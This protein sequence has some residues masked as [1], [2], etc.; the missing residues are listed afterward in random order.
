M[1]VA[2]SRCPVLASAVAEIDRGDDVGIA[3][4]LR[5]LATEEM[6]DQLFVGGEE[7][8]TRRDATFACTQSTCGGDGG[9]TK[10]WPSVLS[11]IVGS[12]REEGGAATAC[13]ILV[14]EMFHF[15]S[16]GFSG[17]L[18]LVRSSTGWSCHSQ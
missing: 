2:V 5:G 4:K 12:Q 3:R 9:G 8:E 10:S 17:Y 14:C 15:Q 13:N 11:F 7:L 6:D 16:S 18:H 1:P